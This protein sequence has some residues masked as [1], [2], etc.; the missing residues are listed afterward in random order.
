MKKSYFCTKTLK[1]TSLEDPVPLQALNIELAEPFLK[2]FTP[3]I[4][5]GIAIML[6][7]LILSGLISG[8]EVAFFSLGPK[9]LKEIR[10]KKGVKNRQIVKLLE[11]PKR[12]LATILISNNFV[13]VAIVMVS[14]FVLT[15]IF[16]LEDYPLWAFVLQV[17]LVTSMLL[18]FGEI[19]PKMLATQNPMKFAVIMALPVNTLLKI[20][21]QFS[22]LLVYSTRIIDKKASNRGYD[23]SINDISQAIDIA[24]GEQEQEKEKKILKGIVNFSDTSVK[25]IM[26]SRVDVVALDKEAS[27]ADVLQTVLDSGYS[28]IPVYEEN[29]DHIQGILYVKDLLP[30]IDDGAYTWQ[31][32]LRSAFYVPEN[33]PISDLLKE[34]QSEKIHLA[35][36]VDEY[37]GTSGIVTLED[38]IEEIVGEINDEFDSADV[39]DHLKLD[40]YNYEFEAKTP[41]NDFCKI[42]G[43]ETSHFDEYRGESDTLAGLILEHEGVIPEKGHKIKI[44]GFTFIIQEVDSRRIVKLKVTIDDKELLE[45]DKD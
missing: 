27:F 33:K 1:K 34:F 45:N 35:I 18:I 39:A 7:L 5:P 23:I 9:Q 28:R 25:E 14:S 40:E 4:I 22:S 16:N 42:I 2:S 32:N 13:N 12:L 3:E 24:S 36:V 17:V 8:S 37:G 44:D 11:R 6:L 19:I 29:F 38:I 41:L 43:I 20:F 31:S 26:K 30:H 21:Y 15:N 10:T